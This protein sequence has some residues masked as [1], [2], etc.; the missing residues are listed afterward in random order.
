MGIK[1]CLVLIGA[2]AFLPLT[3]FSQE[4]PKS[5]EAKRFLDFY[6]HGQG[7][8]VVLAEMKVCEGIVKEGE[9]KNECAGEVAPNSI[10]KG[11][12]YYLWMMYTVPQGDEVK[13][14]V[15][16][17]NR[18]GIT[19]VTKNVSVS[20]S[21]RY[22]VWR[23]FSLK[24]TGNWEIKVLDARGEIVEELGSLGLMVVEAKAEPEGEADSGSGDIPEPEE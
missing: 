19:R 21:I 24:D 22:R 3:A 8:G 16:Q 2:I 7:K 15:I 9:D 1:K 6:Y 13:D 14:I 18:K 12:A 10:E 5:E 11:K 20:G 23:K 4:K 17:F